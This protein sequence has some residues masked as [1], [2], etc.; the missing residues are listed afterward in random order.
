MSVLYVVSLLLTL[1]L[2]TASFYFGLRLGSQS[3][4]MP[5]E[6]AK[7]APAV[8][9]KPK[10]KGATISTPAMREEKLNGRVIPDI[11]KTEELL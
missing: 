6:V 7:Y 4:R 9:R 3:V 8:I 1:L 5:G 10:K 11:I 2:I